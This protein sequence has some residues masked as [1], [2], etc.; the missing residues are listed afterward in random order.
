MAKCRIYETLGSVTEMKH[1]NTSDGFMTLSGVFGVCGVRNRNNRV[2]ETKNYAEMVSRLQKK[3]KEDGAVAGELEHPAGM[4][5]SLENISHK[6]TAI[7]ID[8]NG[9]V[10][11]TIK[12][13]NTP[14]GKIAQ[15][16]VRGGLPLYVSSRASGTIDKSGNVRLENLV[17]YDIVECPGFAQA[18]VNLM[19]SAGES[20]EQPTDNI[21]IIKEDNDENHG[22]S[23]KIMNENN[24]DVLNRLAAMEERIN[25]LEEENRKLCSAGINESN[26]LDMRSLC[27]GIQKWIIEEYSPEVEK[28]IRTEFAGKVKESFKDYIS[29]TVA[30]GIQKW[31]VEE[32]SPEIQKW[33]VNEY[34][35]EVE[36]WV[37]DE[38]SPEVEKW[39][40]EQYSPGVENW[41]INHFAPQVQN[42]MESEYSK[43][44]EDLIKENTE[45][46]KE[47]KLKSITDT[48]ALLENMEPKKPN[49]GSSTPIAPVNECVEPLY[50]AQM[51]DNIRPQ[52]NM[53]DN[54][55]KESIARRAKIYDFSIPGAIQKFWEGIDFGKIKPT[56]SV[57]EDLD[58]IENQREREIRAMFRRHRMNRM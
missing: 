32:Y 29:N 25:V 16:I 31:V 24:N 44:V 46:T 23:D 57:N 26:N 28:W 58:S 40:V 18:R 36:K 43:S 13:L 39:I 55:V 30:P 12:L 37:T 9:K 50:I 19:E 21:L 38:Y 33:V 54:E 27:D 48:L 52:Y 15:E 6:I 17:T 1:E 5:T 51:P 3:I 14:K 49:F 10:T 35:P 22:N 7:D 45:E 47:S 11:G 42:W 2:Y 8:E 41:I 53:A 56:K 34:S 20:A 4:N